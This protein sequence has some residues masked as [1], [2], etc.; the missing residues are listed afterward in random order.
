MEWK[1]RFVAAIAAYTLLIYGA[2][3]GVDGASAAQPVRKVGATEAPGGLDGRNIALWNSHGMYYNDSRG[4]WT[5]QRAPL[6]QTVE[7]VYTSSYVLD[8]I[9]PMLENA[10]AY[11]MLPRERDTSTFEAVLDGSTQSTSKDIIAWNTE[12]P[13]TASY[14]I[15]VR[16]PRQAEPA[17]TAT[18]TVSSLRGEETFIVDQTMGADTWMRLGEFPLAEGLSDVPLVTLMKSENCNRETVTDWQVKIGGGMGSVARGDSL[19]TSGMPRWAEGARYWL[20]YAGFPPEVYAPEECETDYTADIRCRPYWVNFLSGGSSKNPSQKGLNIPIDVALALHTDAGVTED[21]LTVGTLGIYCTDGGKRLADGR[22]RTVNKSLA[23]AVVGQ[24]TDDIRALHNPGWTRRKLRDRRYAEARYPVVPSVLIELLSHQN[25]ADMTWGNDPQFRFDVSRAIYKGLLRFLWSG[26]KEKPTVQPLP[27][28]SF[29]IEATRQEGKYRLSW[30]PT[31]DP[32]EETAMPTH[33]IIEE[34]PGNAAHQGFRQIGRTASTHFEVEIPQGEIRSYRVV[35][36]NRGGRAFPSETLAAG[37]PKEALAEVLVINGFTRISAPEH[38]D[39]GDK[40]GFLDQIDYGVAHTRNVGYIG[41]QY[42]F[43]R[44][45]EWTD[46]HEHPGHG[47]SPLDHV[48]YPVAGN[49][50]DYPVRYGKGIMDSRLAFTS[51]SLEGYLRLAGEKRYKET[52]VKV[53]I[54]GKQRE[55]TRGCTDDSTTRFK[56]FP[57]ELK[58]RLSEHVAHGGNLLVSGSQVATDL[59]ANPWSNDSVA[60]ADISFATDTLRI[61][62]TDSFAATTGDVEALPWWANG[63]QR[64]PIRYSARP[65]GDIYAVESPDALRST[66]SDGETIARYTENSFPAAVA[67]PPTG[68][69]GATV[70]YGFPLEAIF[71]SGAMNRAVEEAML[72]LLPVKLPKAPRPNPDYD[73]LKEYLESLPLPEGKEDLQI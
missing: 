5:F 34:R 37:R 43:D 39:D 56:P 3:S 51:A 19:V 69:L 21:T 40:A 47:A 2:I 13:R 30:L 15:Y 20:E 52:P 68:N 29:A 32:L 53:V 26:R 14:T 1:K 44:A 54:L 58:S 70:V 6:N 24:I 42:D 49:S 64:R 27:V 18:F 59:L 55:I 62:L 7:D 65:N 11:V 36:L 31:P 63:H 66:Q 72:F 12:I 9:A 23:E 25:Y 57:A 45:S 41:S 50:F 4:E 73:P 17:G 38:F 67:N 10:G 35:A 22:R 48:G 8:L 28:R 46:D 33:Y 61:S 16:Y 60:H 71:D